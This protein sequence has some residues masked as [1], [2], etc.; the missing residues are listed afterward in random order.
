MA[1]AGR[2]GEHAP[3]KRHRS[4]IT[5]INQKDLQEAWSARAKIR[6]PHFDWERRQ[7]SKGRGGA[8][9]IKHLEEAAGHIEDLAALCSS[10]FAQ[11]KAIDNVL[12]SL[13]TDFQIL[14]RPDDKLVQGVPVDAKGDEISYGARSAD[15]ADVW[16][17]MLGHVLGL[18][19][20]TTKKQ[21]LGTPASN[22]YACLY[23]G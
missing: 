13:H 15:A 11:Q 17:V 23:E 12:T 5:V 6:F 16:R 4:C 20:S 9:D 22:G 14:S 3:Q 2:H 8:G 21:L 10:G 7:Y 18:R 19:R 1:A